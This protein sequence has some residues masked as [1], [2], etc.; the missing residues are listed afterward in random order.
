MFKPIKSFCYDDWSQK[1]LRELLK[2]DMGLY[3][4]HTNLD[5][6][7]D[8]VTDASLLRQYEFDISEE[9][10]LSNGYGKI[11]DLNAMVHLHDIEDKV[12]VL[13]KIIPDD[14]EING[15]HCGEVV[16]HLFKMWLKKMLIYIS[17]GNLDIMT[18][19]IFGNR[20]WGQWH[21]QLNHLF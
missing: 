3:V 10:D 20:R 1:I 9:S 15:S 12:S 5:R 19:S 17:L 2:K 7:S 16:N 6:A 14:L 18:C 11:V 13:A 8:G 21:Y 4:S